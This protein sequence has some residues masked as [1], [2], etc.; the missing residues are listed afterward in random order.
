[1]GRAGAGARTAFRAVD[2][3]RV[4]LHS[5]K[6]LL[7]PGSGFIIENNYFLKKQLSSSLSNLKGSRPVM[8]VSSP[9]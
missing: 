1:M 2:V 6:I 3:P 5:V 7:Q 4:T 8:S 9:D